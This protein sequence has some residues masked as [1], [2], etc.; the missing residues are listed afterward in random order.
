MKNHLNLR[1]P[2]SITLLTFL[3]TFVVA[4]DS[5]GNRQTMNAN[6]GGSANNANSSMPATNPP[7]SGDGHSLEEMKSSPNAAAAPYDLQFLDT[8]SAHHQG[9]ISMANMALEKSNRGE[10][11]S[12]A[13]KIIQEQERE[14][15]Q[16][17]AWRN[18][19]YADKAAAMNMEMPGME[20]MK[21]MNMDKMKMSSGTEFDLMFLDMMTPHHEGAIKMAREALTKAEHQEIKKLAQQIITDQQAEI[22]QMQ[23]WKT[24]WS[25]K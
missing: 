13:Q 21:G 2:M 19:W 14:I 10:L 23:A 15:A 11:K 9:A 18:Q 6:H 22:N 1:Y 4:C 25:K 17:Q 20:S 5:N 7:M 16:M 3:L 8:M 12:L 24:S